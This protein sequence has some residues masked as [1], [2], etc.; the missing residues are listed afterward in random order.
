MLKAII[1]T[2]VLGTITVGCQATSTTAKSP[3]KL[4]AA[5]PAMCSK[6]DVKTVQIPR[7]EK[8]RTVGYTARKSMECP[9]CKDAVA[10]LVTSGKL[11][12]TCSTCGTEVAQ[13]C[14]GH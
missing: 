1:S 10:N 2:L 7:Q 13:A 6:C 11:E 12:H 4:D 9:D 8:G 3:A 14:L 5:Q